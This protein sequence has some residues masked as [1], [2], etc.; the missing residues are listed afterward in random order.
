MFC[1]ASLQILAGFFL[2][3]G[4]EKIIFVLCYLE[5]SKVFLF[6]FTLSPKWS[7]DKFFSEIYVEKHT[8]YISKF[9]EKFN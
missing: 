6:L 9:Q 1:Q 3:Y 2:E 8:F 4:E 5:D 7:S